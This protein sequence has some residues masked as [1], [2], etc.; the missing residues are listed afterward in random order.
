MMPW[1]SAA[2]LYIVFGI[3]LIPNA[4]PTLGTR[5]DIKKALDYIRERQN[6]NIQMQVQIAEVPSSPF[7]EEQR[8]KFIADEFRQVH[9]ET[10][11]DPKGNVLGWRKG[12]SLRTLVIAAHI[13]TVFPPGTDFTVKRQGTRLN[14]PS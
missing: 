11:I 7:E 10:E 14:G 9:L 13:D 2:L 6:A 4:Q 5:P 3:G 1:I 8:A 12:R